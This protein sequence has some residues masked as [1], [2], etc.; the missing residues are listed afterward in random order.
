M[1]PSNWYSLLFLFH[2]WTTN[3]IY[4]LGLEIER[5]KDL[6]QKAL[7]NFDWKVISC[8]TVLV[9]SI[10]SYLK[11]LF[12]ICSRCL[13]GLFCKGEL[14]LCHRF[15]S[16][17]DCCLEKKMK[18]EHLYSCNV[19]ISSLNETWQGKYSFTNS[20]SSIWHDRKQYRMCY[21]ICDARLRCN[22]SKKYDDP[23]LTS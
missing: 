7:H 9:N 17:F 10:A 19:V 12:N 18:I 14:H 4:Q 22:N 16:S 21:K 5:D 13:Q 11:L 20:H 2:W 8:I 6:L 23:P 15:H 1:M 3:K